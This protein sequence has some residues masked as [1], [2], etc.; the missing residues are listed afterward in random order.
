MTRADPQSPSRF[1]DALLGRAPSTKRLQRFLAGNSRVLR[2]FAVWDDVGGSSPG[3][4]PT[5]RPYKIHYYL[6]DDTVEV[7]EIREGNV[8]REFYRF[9]ARGP[10]PRAGGCTALGG[11]LVAEACVGPADLRIGGTVQVHGRSFFIH[12][13]D[14]FTK[15][16]CK[17]ALGSTEAELAPVDVSLP[18]APPPPRELPP[19]NG[20]GS[21]E[22][23][24]RNC[25]RLVRVA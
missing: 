7:L 20:F 21:F 12:D 19:H 18:R 9:V 17:D 3:G 22:D 13:A 5:R 8:G 4:S 10:L 14:Q 1:A 23:S 15:D 2:Y 24:E 6:E 16:W 11:E 25:T